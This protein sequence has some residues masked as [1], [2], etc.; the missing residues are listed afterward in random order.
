MPDKKNVFQHVQSAADICI[1]HETDSFMLI[2]RKIC[3]SVINITINYS[4]IKCSSDRQNSE[5][6]SRDTHNAVLFPSGELFQMSSI[7]CS[8]FT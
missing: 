3:V 8:D 4:I 6:K 7:N 1:V 5:K 2:V